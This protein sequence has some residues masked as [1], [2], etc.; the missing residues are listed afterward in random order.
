MDMHPHDAAETDYRVRTSQPN[1]HTH[2]K[3]TTHGG[4]SLHKRSNGSGLI[5]I[6]MENTD[7]PLHKIRIWLEVAI[8]VWLW[9]FSCSY[10]SAARTYT[11]VSI[12]WHACAW[13][14]LNCH[15]KSRSSEPDVFVPSMSFSVD[16]AVVAEHFFFFAAFQKNYADLISS[17]WAHTRPR[18]VWITDKIWDVG[19]G[20]RFSLLEQGCMSD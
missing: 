16:A 13:I 18:I 17:Q 9:S 7:C 20:Q 11:A 8:L 6:Q 5:W 1:T 2:T 14:R 19:T 4:T 12:I 10:C 15:L 3:K